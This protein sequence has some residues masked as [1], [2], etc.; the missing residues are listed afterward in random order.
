MSAA[1]PAWVT[2]IFSFTNM[3]IGLAALLAVLVIILVKMGPI[4][5]FFLKLNT[6]PGARTILIAQTHTNELKFY[7]V[8][9]RGRSLRVRKNLYM[10]L[11]DFIR[12]PQKT[13]E[14]VFNDLI[15]KPAHID[16]NPVYMGATSVSVAANPHL[17][18]A[19]SEARDLPK[20][21]ENPQSPD[22]EYFLDI[23]Y[24]GLKD[25]V[26]ADIRR[27]YILNP[28]SLQRLSEL[29][30]VV[31]TPQRQEVV[32]SEGELSGLNRY[33]QRDMVLLGICAILAL[34]MVIMAYFMQRAG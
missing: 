13:D 8:Q 30:N 31:I 19:I 17:M 32:W 3:L 4:G 15:K 26:K 7:R 33:R 25:H 6:L 18:G 22:E 12:N 2:V 28:F 10:F 34:G 23:L 9:D 16:G 14:K 21:D 20:S 29:M 5:R 1:L 27:A 24:E 11:P